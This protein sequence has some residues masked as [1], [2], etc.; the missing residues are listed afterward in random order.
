MQQKMV[1][2]GSVSRSFAEAAE[3]MRHLAETPASAKQVERLTRRVGQERVA[4]RDAATAAFEALPLAQKFAAAEGVTPPD[5]AVV[6]VDGGRLQILD[7]T[8]AAAAA[9]ADPLAAADEEEWEEEK[10]ASGHWRED[11]VGLLATMDSKVSAVDPCPEI[12][13][14]F[15]DATRVPELVREL[16]KHVKAAEDSTT[17]ATDPAAEALEAE[18]TYEPPRVEQR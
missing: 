15:V 17:E 3:L 12:P 6:M 13:P 2:A 9:A 7:R 4:E 14:S 8:G 10:I 1:Y 5:L 16:K 18:A 11:K